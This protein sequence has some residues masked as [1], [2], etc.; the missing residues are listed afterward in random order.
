MRAPLSA[1]E[2]NRVLRID[3]RARAFL[4]RLRPRGGANTPHLLINDVEVV[5]T[6]HDTLSDGSLVLERSRRVK[7]VLTNTAL[8]VTPV[9]N[10][11][12]TR[13]F[14][15]GTAGAVTRANTAFGLKNQ[16]LRRALQPPPRKRARRRGGS[17]GDSRRSSS[18]SS[19]RAT[20]GAASPGDIALRD[21]GVVAAARAAASHIPRAVAVLA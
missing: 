9:S 11:L 18:S 12:L 15:A 8:R 13:A 7:Q 10:T 6:S 5:F 21:G 1:A 17:G 14:D 4:E 20:N 3:P 2:W 16:T 19:R